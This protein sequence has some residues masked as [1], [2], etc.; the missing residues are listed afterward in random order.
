MK[1]SISLPRSLARSESTSA[2]E[3]A[4]STARCSHIPNQITCE[5]A[6]SLRA[7]SKPPIEYGHYKILIHTYNALHDRSPLYIKD[8]L[9][10]YRPSR[11][12]RSQNSLTLV[13]PRARTVRHGQRSFKHSAPSLWN[14]FPNNIREAK[15]IS[16]YNL[17]KNY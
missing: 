4:R 17:S 6:F 15:T 2:T 9:N 3:L 13:I 12:L 1:S 16:E 10:I 7:C 11:T 14:A 8:M 5:R